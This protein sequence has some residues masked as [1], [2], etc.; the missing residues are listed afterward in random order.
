MGGTKRDDFSTKELSL[1]AKLFNASDKSY[2][3][4]NSNIPNS[5]QSFI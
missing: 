4:I 1:Q 2:I 5:S 3:C